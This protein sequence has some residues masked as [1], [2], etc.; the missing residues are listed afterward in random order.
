MRR[1]LLSILALAL[2]LPAFSATAVVDWNQSFV[3]VRLEPSQTAKKTGAIQEGGKVEIVATRGEWAKV[4][5][6]GGEGWVIAK[7]LKATAD[8]PA[9]AAK[10]AE[11]QP[12]QAAAPVVPAAP[13][14]PV[15]PEPVQKPAVPAPPPPGS[16]LAD[17]PDK[18]ALPEV[19][20]GKTLVS[21][22]SGLL[23]VLAIIGAVVWAMRRFLGGKFPQL[24]GTGAIRVLA[25][26]PVAQRQALMLVEVGGEVYLIGQ[27]DS[28]LRLISKI[29]SQAA[30]DRL[31][32]LFT[33]KATKF[34]SEL[35]R[36]LDVESKEGEEPGGPKPE[37]QGFADSIAARLARLRGRPGSSEKT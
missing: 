10:P 6:A 35:R 23:L 5:Y 25:T 2:A 7:S 36:E 31:D 22:V 15:V 11:L 19:S 17:V 34:E 30:V 16:Y 3:N 33:F 1:L 13:V 32:Y 21:M 37:P 8:R 24:S 9:P 29:E 20:I 18:P 14:A 27:S 4:R 28:E 12:A 26:R